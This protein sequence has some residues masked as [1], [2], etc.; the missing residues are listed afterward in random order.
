MS[1][2][3][4]P[5]PQTESAASASAAPKKK[6]ACPPN[7]AGDGIDRPTPPSGDGAAASSAGAAKAQLPTGRPTA[8]GLVS[9]LTTLSKSSIGGNFSSSVTAP[10]GILKRHIHMPGASTKKIK[11]PHHQPQR[12]HVELA[13][14]NNPRMDPYKISKICRAREKIKRTFDGSGLLENDERVFP[15]FEISELTLGKVLG[16]GGFGTVLEI[17]DME[18]VVALSHHRTPQRPPT[19]RAMMMM[20]TRKSHSF[21]LR[22]HRPHYF[23]GSLRFSNSHDGCEG[24]TESRGVGP[25]SIAEQRD[26]RLGSKSHDC[27]EERCDNVLEPLTEDVV[28]L[29]SK[30]HDC[31][32]GHDAL[33]PLTE[34]NVTTPATARD[35]NNRPR[36]E[37]K[38]RALSWSN[39]RA[40]AHVS[41]HYFFHRSPKSIGVEVQCADD[42]RLNQHDEDEDD[43]TTKHGD[44]A[45]E[46]RTKC[47][48]KSV[49]LDESLPTKG[50]AGAVGSDDGAVQGDTPRRASRNFSFL[51]WRDSEAGEEGN[52]AISPEELRK[53]NVDSAYYSTLTNNAEAA[54]DDSDTAY[55]LRTSSSGHADEFVVDEDVSKKGRRI[56]L[57]SPPKNGPPVPPEEEARTTAN[58]HD[59]GHIAQ[60]ATS[61][62]GEARYAIKIISAHIVENDFQKF[63]Q[64][65]M[66]FATETYFLSVLH[67]PN[68]LK[69]RAV[70]QGDMFSPS[71]FLVLDRLYDTLSDRIEGRWKTQSDHLEN[72]IIVWNRATKLKDLWRERMGVMKDLA[73][74]L[75]YLHKLKI[76][77]RDIKPENV[78]FD[79]RGN[80]K[81]FDFGLSKEVHEEDE[82]SNGTYKLTPNTGSIRY[83]APEN[84][85]KWP[86]N[87]SSD[88][89]S[90][91]IML[92]EVAAL[93]RPFLSYTTREIRDMVMKWG[94]RPK[95]KREWPENVVDLM[96]NAW[97]SNFRKRPTM[98][99][100]EATLE[101][102]TE[103]SGV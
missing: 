95:T 23:G 16:Q 19:P 82:C 98:K 93:E 60:H 10:A 48:T 79:S 66:D 49:S 57:H 5:D 53:Y 21:R 8:T 77:Y 15:R 92:W 24:L 17:T 67:H 11:N 30:S 27:V 1:P 75:D 58:H 38:T 101:K 70:G 56:I 43:A 47:S 36:R 32:G 97:D 40:A 26:S 41:S 72:G 18:V 94:E 88:S 59:K 69:L 64:A 2:F 102:E 50:A 99:A 7:A 20:P 28:A 61:G 37:L 51:A 76:I 73:G 33:E 35:G 71:Y 91:G 42:T 22:R 80:V 74:A 96:K 54:F 68:I 85:N 13:A 63:L 87:F 90:F 39:A 44:G 84:G 83:M 55:P 45:R 3:E 29:G 89:Y 65:S 86:Y 25:G 100:I 62:E 46:E 52:D 34:G 81:L 31:L 103:D 14:T 4:P 12:R 78:G 6:A 9:P